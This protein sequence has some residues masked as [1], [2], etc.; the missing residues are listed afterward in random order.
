MTIAI[1]RDPIYRRRRFEGEAIEACV[2]WYV[3]YRLSYRDVAALMAERGMHVSHTTILRWVLHYVPEF[4][5]RWSRRVH[6]S[7]RV[8]ETYIRVRAKGTTSIVLWIST[9]RRWIFF[10]GRIAALQPRRH[11]FAKR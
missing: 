8:D 7:W 9:A 10:F 6:S 2:R 4:E 1:A 5:N 3:T 11:S